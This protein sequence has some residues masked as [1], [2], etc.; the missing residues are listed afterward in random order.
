MRVPEGLADSAPTRAFRFRV[1]ARSHVGAVRRMNE[2][3]LL[4][5]TDAGVWAVADGMGGHEAGDHASRR[6]VESLA[7]ALDRQPGR[8]D[9]ADLAGALDHCNAELCAYADRHGFTAVGSTIVALTVQGSGFD[10]VWAGDSRLYRLRE[11]RLHLLTHDHS[12]VQH[13]VDAGRLDP[14]S[15]ERHPQANVITRAV[16]AVP[17]LRLDH[18]RGEV[19][20]GDT[21][22]LCSD[23]LTR[24][25][26]A[27]VLESTLARHPPAEAVRRLEA[28]AL[29]NG[30]RDNLSMVAIR[31]L[32]VTRPDG[33][34]A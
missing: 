18:I 9:M 4:E 10:A 8:A 31:C 17:A 12:L 21:F 30:A 28:A 13:L 25:V 7:A 23:G 33:A 6:V 16:G 32:S 15:A 19:R 27:G 11:G 14:A 29:H 20:H 2:D 34:D 3:A 1:A 24:E 5:R 22:L 26:A